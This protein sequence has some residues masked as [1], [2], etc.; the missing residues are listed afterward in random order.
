MY[1]VDTNIINRLV[2][3]QLASDN[4]PSDG[5]FIATHIQRDELEKTPDEQRRAQ[6]RAKFKETIDREVLT[7]STV[8]GVSRIGL[9][10]ISDGKRYSSLRDALSIRNKGKPNNAEDALIAEV[11]IEHGWVLLTADRDLAEVAKKHGCEVEYY[12][13]RRS[14]GA[15][16]EKCG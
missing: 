9:A 1:V 15:E 14:A 11:A 4:L 12:P 3:G 16:P 7:E 13:P 6:L 5:N 8:V 10:R 2:D